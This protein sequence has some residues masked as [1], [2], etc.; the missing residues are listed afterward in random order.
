MNKS[1]FISKPKI[2]CYNQHANLLAII[3]RNDDY[4]PWFYNNYLQLQFTNDLF[5]PHVGARLDFEMP[6]LFSA[7]PF[8]SESNLS[9]L[10]I[11]RIWKQF[12][13]FIIEMINSENYIYVT[14]DPFY[15]ESYSS[16]QQKHGEHPILIYGYDTSKQICYVADNFG[17]GNYQFRIIPINQIQTAYEIFTY[18]DRDLFMNGVTL[19]HYE[20]HNQFYYWHHDYT[21][22]LAFLKNTINDF[23]NSKGLNDYG[24][25]GIE[26]WKGQTLVYGLECYNRIKEYI[27]LCPFYDQRLFFVFWEHK[28]IMVERIHY[29]SQNHYFRHDSTTLEYEFKKIETDSNVLNNLWLKFGITQNQKDLCRIKQLFLNIMESDVNLLSELYCSLK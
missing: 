15:I 23:L 2:T 11:S 17:I 12:K 20:N 14:V 24:V 10:L 25:I 9:R 28:K 1:L 27:N 19:F 3:A 13:D 18:N 8:I 21:F 29:L 7:C 26:Q 22:D 16:Y 4:L 6:L 5:Y